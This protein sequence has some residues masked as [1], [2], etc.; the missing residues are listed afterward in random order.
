[1]RQAIGLVWKAFGWH[2]V[3][4]DIETTPELAWP[5]LPEHHARWDEATCA[6]VVYLFSETVN[7]FGGRPEEFFRAFRRKRPDDPGRSLRIA[8]IDIGG[9]TTDLVICDYRLDEGRGGNVSIVPEQTFRDGFKVA[10]DDILLDVIQKMVVPPIREALLAAGVAEPDPVLSA[11]IGS[12]AGIVQEMVL[13]QQLTLQVLLPL[14]L[15]LLKAY[16]RYDPLTGGEVAAMTFAEALAGRDAPSPEVL[17][18]F[19]KGVRRAAPGAAAFDLMQVRLPFDMAL[20][21]RLFVT[22][23]ME[24]GK[25]IRA[26]CEVVYLYDCDVLLLSGRPSCLPGVQALFRGLLALPPDRV[27]PLHRY[28]TGNWY[29][30]H[31]GGRIDDPKT[32]AAVGAMLCVLGQG[33]I[34]NFF[35]RANVFRMYSTVRNIGLMD[36]NNAIKDA[37]VYY[38]DVDFDDPDWDFPQDVAFD[39]RGRMILGFRQLDAARWGASPLYIIEFAGGEE[40]AAR[41]A[42]YGDA[43]SG[44]VLKVKLARKRRGKVDRPV[45][46]EVSVAGGNGSVGRNALTIGLYTLPVHGAGVFSHWLDTGSVI[47]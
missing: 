21:H 22:D 2:P 20:L 5:P 30:F 3:D 31:K 36:Q 25:P 40:S 13:R 1:M 32:T 27:I 44:A 14:G 15:A 12:E 34:P 45:L 19:R 17:D 39:V 46:S 6:Q 41:R 43:N 16:E 37:D 29:P 8:S 42:L 33:R 11:L 23:K 10:G 9:G 38:R 7:H 4:P 47:R 26:L 24:I 28:R 18:Y 35:F